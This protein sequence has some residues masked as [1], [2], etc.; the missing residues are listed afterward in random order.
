M[1]YQRQDSLQRPEFGKDQYQVGVIGGSPKDGDAT[2]SHQVG[3]YETTCHSSSSLRRRKWLGT[4]LLHALVKNYSTKCC[5]MFLKIHIL[6]DLDQV[7][8]NM[9]AYSKQFHQ[10]ILDFERSYQGQ[11]NISESIL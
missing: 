3:P 4:D 1:H 9:G 6:D 7:K 5:R 10:D 8:D 2:T 11:C